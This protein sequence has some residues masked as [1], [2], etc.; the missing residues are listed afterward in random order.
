MV[1]PLDLEPRSDRGRRTRRRLL[2]A[3]AVVFAREGFLDTKITDITGEANVAN[4]TFYNYFDTK[5]AIFKAVILVTIEEMF[6]A[7]AVPPGTSRSP[8]TRIE[9]ATSNYVSAVRQHA[10]LLAIL[11]QV[12]TFNADFTAMRREIRQTFRDRTAK[13]LVRMQDEGLVDRSLSADVAAEALTSM[14]SNFCYVWL[15]LG[16]EYDERTAV[17]TLT[18]LWGRGIGLEPPAGQDGPGGELDL[19]S[20]TT[21]GETS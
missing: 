13:G 5:E 3:A 8:W 6:R 18:T 20:T 17:R 1:E 9:T 11:E 4:G 21:E 15:V 19:G 16:E 7:A 12:A 2:D 14:V 10:G